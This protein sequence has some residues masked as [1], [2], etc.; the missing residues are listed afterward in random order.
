MKKGCDGENGKKKKKNGKWKIM[1]STNA[2]SS[3]PPY[4]DRLE[5]AC[6]YQY[7]SRKEREDEVNP[8]GH[9]M[10]H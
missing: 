9:L 1:I 10:K 3:R 2:V 7:Y 8:K 4:A 6:S 5:C